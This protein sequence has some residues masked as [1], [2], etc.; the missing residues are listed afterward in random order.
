MS[1]D[2]GKKK[3][4]EA[5]LAACIV[6]FFTD[7][8]WDVYQEVQVGPMM[9]RADLVVV[10]GKLV[11]IIECKQALGLPVMEQAFY[12][13]G[14]AHFVWVASWYSSRTGGRLS[15]RILKDYG[16]GYLSMSPSNCQ[17][18]L[19]INNPNEVV[20]PTLLRCPPNLELLTQKLVP[21]QKTVVAAG[22][23]RGGHWTPFKST[24]YELARIAKE[25]PGI[26]LKEALD[27][28]KHHYSNTRSAMCHLPEWIAKG[29]VP[30]VLLDK[31]D[32]KARL[33]L[34]PEPRCDT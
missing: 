25:K 34:D 14:Y 16:I 23:N 32:G 27:S 17:R 28:F 26:T 4:T 5:D 13:R 31:S 10:Q 30:G 33:V 21:E 22:G 6:R 15:M 18:T 20:A 19:E 8:H 29:K 7:Q 24:C 3:P 2:V 1:K 9:P 11:G 12:W